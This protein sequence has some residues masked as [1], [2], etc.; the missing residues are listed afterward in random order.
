MPALPTGTISIS[1]INAEFGRG[2]NLG[3]YRGVQWY[4]DAG[5]SGTFSST[6]LA[7]SQFWGKRAT[8][9]GPSYSLTGS[10]TSGSYFQDLDFTFPYNTQIILRFYRNGS[11]DASGIN[12]FYD[13]G[14]W[15]SPTNTTAGDGYWIRFTRTSTMGFGGT[16]TASTGW[17]QLNTTQLIS[18]QR[19]GNGLFPPMVVPQQYKH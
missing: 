12:G 7:M 14:N 6:D 3:A 15:V 11:W 13:S 19:S 4:T 5:G 10:P 17:L 8:A 2:T 16:S 9:P 1:Q 18:A